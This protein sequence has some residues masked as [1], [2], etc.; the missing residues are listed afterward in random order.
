M[1]NTNTPFTYR[2]LK[3]SIYFMFLLY[4][5]VLFILDSFFYKFLFN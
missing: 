4:L 1:K 3:I 2:Y 5:H